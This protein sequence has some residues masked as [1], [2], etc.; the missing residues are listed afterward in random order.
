MKWL[1]AVALLTLPFATLHAQEAPDDQKPIQCDSCAAWNKAQKPFKIYGNTWYVGTAGLSSVLITSPEGHILIDG[2]LPQS[3]PLIEANIKAA[4][5][6]IEDVR[7]ILSSHAHFDH[8]GGIAYLQGKSGARVV[9]SAEG[10]R[11]LESGAVAREDAQYDS[12]KDMTFPKVKNVRAVRNEETLGVGSLRVTTRLTPGHSPDSA[13]WTWTSCDKDACRDMVF[14]DSLTPVADEG[15]RFSG[16]ATH[17]D[18][19]A[20]FKASIAKVRALSCDIMIPAHP[21]TKETGKKAAPRKGAV[22][23]AAAGTVFTVPNG[24]KAYA[25]AADKALDKRLAQEKAAK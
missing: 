23:K 4:G 12:L 2:G 9:A 24:C 6:K 13:S 20:A 18:Q 5:F 7:M 15:Y 11:V 25:N 10:A 1:A 19:S 21:E 22:A 8:A 3:G 14:A 16:D 17:P